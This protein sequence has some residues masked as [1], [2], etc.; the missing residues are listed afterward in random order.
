[1]KDQ[2]CTIST[3]TTDDLAD[4]ARKLRMMAAVHNQSGVIVEFSPAGAR[5][6]AEAIDG[7][8]WRGRLADEVA[9]RVEADRARQ[10]AEREAWVKGASAQVRRDLIQARV[11]LG[12]VIVMLVA[13][14]VLG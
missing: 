12:L 9:V 7:G 11:T 14:V 2:P 10:R 6:V 8:G 5:A 13:G 3:P 1:M 4:V